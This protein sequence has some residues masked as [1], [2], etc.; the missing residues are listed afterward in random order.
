MC[1][2]ALCARACAPSSAPAA[3][4]TGRPSPEALN[5]AFDK[6]TYRIISTLHGGSVG[7]YKDDVSDVFHPQKDLSV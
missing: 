5:I 4:L 6:H 1:V 7:R 3:L 2:V